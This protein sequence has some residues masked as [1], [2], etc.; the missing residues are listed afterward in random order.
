VGSKVRHWFFSANGRHVRERLFANNDDTEL[1]MARRL[2]RTQKAQIRKYAHLTVRDIKRKTGF[3]LAA[4]HGVL[5][6]PSP[7]S[8]RGRKA[9]ERSPAQ[10][11]PAAPPMPLE[12]APE[13]APD[14]VERLTN[15][16]TSLEDLARRAAADDDHARSIQ[17]LRAIGDLTSTIERIRPTP[18][19]D[20]NENPD[21]VQAAKDARELVFGTLDRIVAEARKP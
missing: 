21:F 3:S 11:K 16:I 8:C 1:R 15:V 4:I 6:E 10:T 17:A 7:A 18:P 9:A 14:A 20:P 12:A 13:P 2:T 5:H 19:A